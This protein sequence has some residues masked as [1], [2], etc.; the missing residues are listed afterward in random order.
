M[1]RAK[2]SQKP[3]I[4]NNVARRR[5]IR[6]VRRLRLLNLS[7]KT[8]AVIFQKHAIA[9]HTRKV[10]RCK[11][12]DL[13]NETLALIFQHCDKLPLRATCSR[14][15]S[16]I[17]LT[18]RQQLLAHCFRNYSVLLRV[19]CSSL[20]SGAQYGPTWLNLSDAAVYR[21]LIDRSMRSVRL[22]DLDDLMSVS[23]RIGLCYTYDKYTLQTRIDNLRPRNTHEDTVLSALKH[24]PVLSLSLPPHIEDWIR[25]TCQSDYLLAVFTARAQLSWSARK[26]VIEQWIDDMTDA[27]ISDYLK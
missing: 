4:Q 13:P 19:S 6:K 24:K 9:K 26:A 5:R 17:D 25:D 27:E 20:D 7:N 12:L 14:F 16:M 3:S 10:R 2:A 18:P 8:R 23:T 15:R 1:P 11:L 21:K 22:L